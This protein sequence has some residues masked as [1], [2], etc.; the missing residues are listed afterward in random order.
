[1]RRVAT[2]CLVSCLLAG[3][4]S[5]RLIQ[6]NAA[7]GHMP[8]DTAIPEEDRFVVTGATYFATLTPSELV[9]HDFLGP[10]RIHVGR[11][12]EFGA[13]WA[14]QIDARVDFAVRP[15]PEFALQSGVLDGDRMVVLGVTPTEVG[16][17]G[18]SGS[19]W[20]GG[21]SFS[22]DTTDTIHRYDVQRVDGTIRLFIDGSATPAIVLPAETFVGTFSQGILLLATSTVGTSRFEIERFHVETGI[23]ATAA[24]SPIDSPVLT[25][26]PNPFNPKTS[27][28]FRVEVAGE[29]QLDVF[30]ARGRL[31]QQLLEGRLEVG[32]HHVQWHGRDQHGRPVSSGSY[33]VQLLSAG[34]S[35]VERLVLA[36]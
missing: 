10:E 32:E 8:W 36:K 23:S 7:S 3:T 27:I 31:V 29:V 12:Q 25:I 24:P 11:D 9:I 14:L 34:T 22:L 26:A 17:I 6:W 2:V 4:S 1:M 28:R 30:D 15:Y 35:S 18:S 21:Q 5:A 20:V 19:A 33:W 13:A 16:F